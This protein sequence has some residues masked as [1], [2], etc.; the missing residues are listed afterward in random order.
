M[1][2]AFM[3]WCG[4]PLEDLKFKV[5]QSIPPYTD[6]ATVNTVRAAISRKNTHK[7]SIERDDLLFDFDRQSE[8]R[9]AERENLLVK[10]RHAE[11][12]EVRNW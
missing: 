2:I 11:Y 8:T 6:K 3:K 4:E 7:K 10:H 12:V 5:P 1:I 9:R